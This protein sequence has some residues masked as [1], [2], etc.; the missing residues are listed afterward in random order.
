MKGRLLTN[1]M[2]IYCD[3]FFINKPAFCN[4]LPEL[5]KKIYRVATTC[6]YKFPCAIVAQA[7]ISLMTRLFQGVICVPIKVCMKF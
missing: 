5:I 7:H 6:F 3:K 1:K 2:H 4:F